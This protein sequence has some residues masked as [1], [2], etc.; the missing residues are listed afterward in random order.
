M[1]RIKDLALILSVVMISCGNPK[2][3]PKP[4]TLAIV[5]TGEISN[6]TPTSALAAGEVVLDGNT[7]VTER[8]FTYGTT[9]GPTIDGLKVIS[10]SGVGPFA[11][12]LGN[13][14][15]ATTYH[16]RAYALN[17]KGVSYGIE[18][19]FTTGQSLPVLTTA[20][21]T[22]I[23]A[24][25]AISGG[26]ISS[27][28][29]STISARGICWN[30]IGNPTL[31]D[32]K[33]ID[34]SGVG[35][36]SSNLV[37]L[38]SITRIYV[39]AYA[40]N[41]VGT[42]YGNQIEVVTLKAVPNNGL[43]AWWPFNGNANDESGNG[44]HGTVYGALLTS[45]RLGNNESAYKFNGNSD[46]IKAKAIDL[47]NLTFSLWYSIESGSNLNPST[48]HP[49]S[50]SQLI[51][52]GTQLSPTIYCDYSLGITDFNTKTQ[53]S[54]EQSLTASNFQ[55]YYTDFVMAY[56][57]WVNLVYRIE[58]NSCTIYEN[59]KVV[60]NF[61]LTGDL[62]RGGPDLSIGGRFIT[63]L[64]AIT[65]FF[66]GSIDDVAIWNRALTAE[67]ILKIYNGTGF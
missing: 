67:E 6:I 4:T 26:I 12:T 7:V 1:L 40:T 34:G 27:D 20:A 31:T 21:A 51:A 55:M 63:N 48:G 3:D 46:Y 5:T 32:N 56:A 11:V 22:S 38:K 45:D 65:N 58:S 16:L 14:T 10:G 44:N 42:A 52:Q 30:T 25:S 54:F 9:V 41:N 57:S 64:N 43:I 39:R 2:E 61:T 47:S 53:Y 36:Y 18:R 37:S 8:G 15:P 50:G 66:K 13:L 62:S 49:P 35:T 17:S 59:G 24:V 60:G 33:T 23:T 28:G 19:T 29:G